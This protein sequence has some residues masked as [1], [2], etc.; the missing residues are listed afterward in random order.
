VS[1]QALM[2][3]GILWCVAMMVRSTSYMLID[4]DQVISC[5]DRMVITGALALHM[6]SR[7]VTQLPR[8]HVYGLRDSEVV[9]LRVGD[10]QVMYM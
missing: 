10:D 1:D 5:I 9:R 3:T 8:L 4:V 6:M 7:N 2:P